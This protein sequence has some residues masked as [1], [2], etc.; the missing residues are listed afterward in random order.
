MQLVNDLHGTLA[1]YA[2]CTDKRVCRFI[3]SN[4]QT[5]L[6]SLFR[7]SR[8]SEDD[9]AVGVDACTV[10][11][12]VVGLVVVVDNRAVGVDACAV[13]D[14]V[15]GL[16][17]D[18]TPG[19]IG[20]NIVNRSG[21]DAHT[22]G[23]VGTLTPMAAAVVPAVP[24]VPAAAPSPTPTPHIHVPV[25]DPAVEATCQHSGLTAG[26]HCSVCGEIL[27]PR[28]MIPLQGHL[29]VDGFCVWC[30]EPEPGVGSYE[31]FAVLLP[32]I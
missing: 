8:F 27:T 10:D 1:V 13:D 17:V 2:Q 7:C 5:L 21:R 32:E 29:Y 9:A 22:D 4:L 14:D 26:S 25:A 11:V 24:T 3:Q 28:Q 18:V 31:D 19:V 6:L 12:D 30:G 15:V 20:G 23:G 16:I